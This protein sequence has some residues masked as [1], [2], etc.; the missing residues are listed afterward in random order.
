MAI[1]M[2]NTDGFDPMKHA[3]VESPKTLSYRSGT[4]VDSLGTVTIEHYSAHRIEL[5]VDAKENALLF[6]SEVWYP[7]WH[8]LVDGKEVPILRTNYLFRGIELPGGKHKVVFY[9]RSA[10]FRKGLIL[11]LI[12]LSLSIA[13]L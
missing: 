3:V 4:P 11:S 2:I 12:S 6:A 8:A 5:E 9:Y 1:E 7:A 13:S 10:A